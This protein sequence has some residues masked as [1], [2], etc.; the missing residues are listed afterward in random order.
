MA[1]KLAAG[2]WK[3]NGLDADIDGFATL[4]DTETELLICPPST[5]IPSL[6]SQLPEHIAIGGQDCHSETTGAYTGD[7]SAQ[8]L[9]IAGASHVIVGH[10]ERREA[11]GETDQ[12]VALKAKAAWDAGLT[13]IICIGE[14]LED[15]TEGQTLDV[16]GTA[17][18]ASVPEGATNE[19]TIIAYEPIWAIGTG[20]T[21]TLAQIG[22]VHSA[23]QDI[24]SER[25]GA[26]FRLLYGGSMKPENASAI[27]SIDN[28]HGGLIGGASLKVADFQAIVDAIT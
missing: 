20:R 9:R 16:I 1:R 14:T 28:V 23:I 26:A 12:Q 5:M 10:S 7:I 13:S 2:N 4:P 3:M 22:E 17:L 11:H 18:A 27:T 25:F 15:R 24:L 8:M 6:R 21:P 19:T